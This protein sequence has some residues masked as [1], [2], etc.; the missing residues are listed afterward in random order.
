MTGLTR[1]SGLP[2]KIG[3][4]RRKA[5]RDFTWQI[6]RRGFRGARGKSSHPYNQRNA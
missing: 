4:I 3:S 2:S 1:E 6:L 5:Q